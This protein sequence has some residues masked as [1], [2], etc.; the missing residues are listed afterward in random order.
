MA[1][2]AVR[3]AAIGLILL[4]LAA[5][6]QLVGASAARPKLTPGQEVA[7]ATA[8]LR[9]IPAAR[10]AEGRRTRALV[11]QRAALARRALRGK[12]ACFSVFA[13]DRVLSILHQPTTWRNRAPRALIRR[14]VR[15]LRLAE[16]SSL[17]RAGPRCARTAKTRRLP[18]KSADADAIVATPATES[19]Q[20]EG[21][22]KPLP[23]GKMRP[24]GPIGGNVELGASPFS[25]R[26][27][28]APEPINLFRTTD[29]GRP[30]RRGGVNEPTSAIGGNVVWYTGNTSVGLSIDNGR[31]F[32]LYDPSTVL[33]DAGLGLCCDQL[34]SYSPQANLFVWVLQYWCNAP[35]TGCEDT[36]SKGNKSCSTKGEANRIRIAFATP[37]DLVRHAT[38]PLSVPW[39]SVWRYVDITPAMFGLRR[40]DWFDRSA[41]A[42]N[43]WYVN[44][45]VDVQCD[46]DPTN[47]HSVLARIRLSDLTRRSGSVP[48]EYFLDTEGRMEAVQNP[49]GTTTYFA[50]NNSRSQARI[51]S[52]EPFDNLAIRHDMNHYSVPDRYAD[53][54][55]L[56]AKD[57]NDRWG[58]FPFD[59]QSATVSGD[60]MYLAQVTGREL[61]IDHCTPGDPAVQTKPVFDQPAIFISRYDIVDW[62]TVGQR[63]LWNSTLAFAWPALQTDGL[64]DVGISF[65]ASPVPGDPRPVVG[66]LTPDE[67]FRFAFPAGQPFLA[68]DYYSLRPGRT[69]STFVTP[70]Q[71]VQ[72][73]GMHWNFIEYGHGTPPYAA[74]PNVTITS[75]KNLETVPVGSV[76]R[77]AAE[78]SDPVDGTLPE[79]AIEWSEGAVP[80][81]NGP[82]QYHAEMTA[83]TFEI[84]VKATNGDGKST[85]RSITI[86]VVN[87]P[88]PGAPSAAITAPPDGTHY[89]TNASDHAGD[90]HVV[91]FQATASDP[92]NPPKPLTYE[93]TDSEDGA[94]RVVVSTQL[95]P[96][97]RVYLKPYDQETTHDFR[98]TVSNGVSSATADVRVY[99]NIPDYCIK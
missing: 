14:P 59:V 18:L 63:W 50:G 78:V 49:A 91:A 90:Y 74:P 11:L 70:A 72:S 39:R 89:C 44:W 3:A 23:L 96:T 45:N 5:T 76:V 12:R 4:A 37:Q 48:L 46:R 19:D 83:G 35:S 43:P 52:W 16:R 31:T 58:G 85:T 41:L 71:T 29:I 24:P 42:V 62:R 94:P 66:F 28:A 22:N 6:A 15:L 68:G 10:F 27:G 65:R 67:Q 97:L 93:W 8:L 81:G 34:V 79:K 54:N 7:R 30:P 77:Y 53:I 57:W 99:I 25:G 20:G 84:S 38:T 33:P 56:D 26:R 51:W 95:S 64:G 55:G 73:D 21:L 2:G 75:P 60:T 80:F 1:R 98:L 92:N 86:R 61:C 47:W 82:Q 9:R 32:T 17:R 87:P 88:P 69:P 36:D 40:N 13:V